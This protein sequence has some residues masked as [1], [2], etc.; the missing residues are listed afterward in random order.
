LKPEQH[1]DG[2]SFLPL[3]K[4]QTTPRRKALFWHYPHYS[5]QGGAP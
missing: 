4:S 3:L 1:L 2:I 5:N